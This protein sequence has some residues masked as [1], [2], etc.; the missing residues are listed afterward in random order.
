[1]S[2]S[3]VKA[4]VRTV[5]ITLY[6]TPWCPHCSRARQWL[7]HN[8]IPFVERDIEKDPA[9]RRALTALNPRGGVPTIDVDGQVMVGFC[10]HQVGE[11]I[12]RAVQRRLQKQ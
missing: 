4:L 2:P 10:E 5:P 8:G 6:T 3:Q 1:M 12:A 11:A 9:N 7:R